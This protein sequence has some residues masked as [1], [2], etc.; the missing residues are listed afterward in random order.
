MSRPQTNP[1]DSTGNDATGDDHLL[2]RTIKEVNHCLTQPPHTHTAADATDY[3][4][5]QPQDERP[6]NG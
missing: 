2:P 6:G 5:D 4:S 1:N 3:H